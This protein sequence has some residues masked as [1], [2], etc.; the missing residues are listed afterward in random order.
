[1]KSSDSP[2]VAH[3]RRELEISKLF[4]KSED[5]SYD[6]FIALG[7]L[8]LV[9]IFSKWTKGDPSRAQAIQSVFNYV[10]EGDLL[11]PPTNDPDEWEDF[12]VEGEMIRRNK[13]NIFYITRD[14]SKTWLNLRNNQRGICN[15]HETGK[16]LEGVKDP[17]GEAEQTVKDQEGSADTGDAGH[18]EDVKQPADGSRDSTVDDSVSESR[19]GGKDATPASDGKPRPD[20]EVNGAELNARPDS[21]PVEKGKLDSGVEQKGSENSSETEA[22][23]EEQKSGEA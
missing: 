7:V 9:K 21:I 19:R 8:S 12:E 18:R 10:I 17:N 6:G 14:D 3:A 20:G 15:D 11:S 22:G 5:G 13:R 2:I 1:M 23:T 16:P 4:T